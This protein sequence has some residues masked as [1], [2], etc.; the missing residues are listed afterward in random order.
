MGSDAI[1]SF[2]FYT[3][4]HA[5][6]KTYLTQQMLKNKI[7]ATNMIYVTIFIK[8]NIILLYTSLKDPIFFDLSFN[9]KKILNSKVSFKEKRI[10]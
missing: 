7:L 2:E 5:Q 9:I 6:N 10:N 4:N 1:P 3:W 8:K